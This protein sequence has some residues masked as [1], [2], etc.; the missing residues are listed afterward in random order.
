MAAEAGEAEVVFTQSCRSTAG[1]GAVGGNTLLA[2]D[3]HLQLGW[4]PSA[5][6]QVA[7]WLG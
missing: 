2:G 1:L 6:V 3:N 4:E 5:M 7:S